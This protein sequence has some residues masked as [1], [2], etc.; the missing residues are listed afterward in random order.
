MSKIDHA[1]LFMPDD[2][3]RFVVHAVLLAVVPACFVVPAVN[4]AAVGTLPACDLIFGF[5]AH[6]SLQTPFER[7]STGK[8]SLS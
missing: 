5:V 8:L 2:H 1:A 3:F 4:A 7:K 6:M